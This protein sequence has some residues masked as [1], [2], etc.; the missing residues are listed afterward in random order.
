MCDYSLEL[1]Q[2]S[3]WHTVK[4]KFMNVSIF[5][6][7]ANC[8]LAPRGLSKYSHRHDGNIDLVITKDVSRMQFIRFLRRHGNS[9]N[10]VIFLCFLQHMAMMHVV[11]TVMQ[12]T[13]QGYYV[14]MLYSH[15]SELCSQFLWYCVCFLW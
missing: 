3:P 9:K 8:S 2:D 7:A 1:K 15:I 11:S 14:Y 6:I 5:G 12:A 13:Q 4:G 10:Q